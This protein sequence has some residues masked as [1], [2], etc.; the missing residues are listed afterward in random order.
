MPEEQDAHLKR[1]K[2][3]ERKLDFILNVVILS[4]SAAFA[5]GAALGAQELGANGAI[6]TLVGLGLGSAAYYAIRRSFYT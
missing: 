2:R 5:Y 6:A 1:L 3:I 4:L